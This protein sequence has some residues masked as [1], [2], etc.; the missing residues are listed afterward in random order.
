MEKSQRIHSSAILLV[1]VNLLALYAATEPTA[2]AQNS[3]DL[4]MAAQQRASSASEPAARSFV[5]DYKQNTFL[6]DDKP[7][8]Y[9]KF[10]IGE[11]LGRGGGEGRRGEGLGRG[12]GGGGEGRR[13]EGLGRGR[14]G[15]G[16][17]RGGE[18]A[19]AF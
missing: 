15:G 5:I 1:V 16:E 9:L 3:K 13:G 4:N 14:G 2:A 12:R 17:E 11:G 18:A 8:R 7:F 19:V 6:K 10:D